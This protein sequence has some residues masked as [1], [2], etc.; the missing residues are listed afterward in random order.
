[1]QG[2]KYNIPVRLWLPETFPYSAPLV[3]VEPTQDMMIM[4]S[5]PFVNANGAVAT[6]YLRQW[7]RRF[8]FW[9]AWGP[10][11]SSAAR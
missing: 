9:Q 1:M 8:A 2:A 7:G 3:F 11:S 6:D 10:H 4:N 5:H